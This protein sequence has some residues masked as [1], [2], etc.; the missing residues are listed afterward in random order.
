[1]NLPVTG[2]A[3]DLQVIPSLLALAIFRE[4]M[5]IQRNILFPTFGASIP[6]RGD[7]QG[8][9]FLPLGSPAVCAH[10]GQCQIQQELLATLWD[11]GIELLELDPPDV[12]G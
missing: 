2:L 3:H 8:C 12:F 11:G 1:V 6:S 9:L 10:I 4:M 7:L 5:D